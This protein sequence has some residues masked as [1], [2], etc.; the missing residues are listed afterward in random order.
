MVFSFSISALAMA[1]IYLVVLVPTDGRTKFEDRS[2]PALNNQRPTHLLIAPPEP[3]Y[4]YWILPRS[5]LL[6][7]C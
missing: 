7:L 6:P 5:P 1:I 4:K 3:R 2:L